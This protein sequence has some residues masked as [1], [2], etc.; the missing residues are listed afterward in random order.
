M[1][2]MYLGIKSRGLITSEKTG[3]A[4]ICDFGLCHVLG[5]KPTAER[6]TVQWATPEVM[7]QTPSSHDC[8][9]NTHAFGIYLWELL[10]LTVPYQQLH[11]IRM[12]IL[13]SKFC[14]RPPIA[15]GCL[16]LDEYLIRGRRPLETS[17]N[18]VRQDVAGDR[19][20]KH[21]RHLR[22]HWWVA[23]CPEQEAI[24]RAAVYQQLGIINFV[25]SCSHFHMPRHS[26]N[27][28]MTSLDV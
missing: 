15:D 2:F 5:P 4:V 1:R 3:E 8:S 10:T 28:S 25:C 13:V 16:P 11:A 23:T 26:C 27:E 21:Q 17:S 24:M 12:C 20:R 14:E 6:G 18:I 9:L 7:T 19:S 22:T